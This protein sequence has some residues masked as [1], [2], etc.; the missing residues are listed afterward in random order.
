MPVGV[1]AEGVNDLKQQIIEMAQRGANLRPAFEEAGDELLDIQRDYLRSP[2]W[3][4]LSPAYAARKARQG[5]GSRAGVKTGDMFDSLTRE[6]DPLHV[7]RI[8]PESLFFGSKDPV[9]KLFQKGSFRPPS[10]RQPPRR[11]IKLTAKDRKR[12]LTIIRDHVLKA[13]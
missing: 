3:R 12:L 9:A 10:N 2:N 8:K 5:F 1:H 11:L 13:D 7:E 6:N 4:P